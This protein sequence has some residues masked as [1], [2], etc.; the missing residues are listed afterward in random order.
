MPFL[1][2]AARRIGIKT[3]IGL[4]EHVVVVYALLSSH[5]FDNV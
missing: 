3:S 4:G 5:H 1:G 2:E